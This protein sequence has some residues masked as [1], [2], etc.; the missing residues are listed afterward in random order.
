MKVKYN[1]CESLLPV[2][3]VAGEGPN[4]MGRDCFPLLPVDQLS[5]SSSHFEEVLQQHQG[6]VGLPQAGSSSFV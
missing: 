2:H 3:V 6:G 5:H 1:S 4:L